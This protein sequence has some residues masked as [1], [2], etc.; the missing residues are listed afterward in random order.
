MSFK[1]VKDWVAVAKACVATNKAYHSLGHTEKEELAGESLPPTMS[2]KLNGFLFKRDFEKEL[3]NATADKNNKLLSLPP[4]I[5]QITVLKTLS[6]QD[7]PNSGMIL[8]VNYKPAIA[9]ASNIHDT[10]TTFREVYADKELVELIRN[11]FAIG[12]LLEPKNTVAQ[13]KPKMS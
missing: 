2:Q 4:A 5:A 13:V 11:R 8:S 1:V 10:T 3:K 9:C 7:N 12:S 6:A